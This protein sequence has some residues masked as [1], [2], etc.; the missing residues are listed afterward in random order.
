MASTSRSASLSENGRG[1]L[2]G[3]ACH[4]IVLSFQNVAH[5]KG[6]CDF[7]DILITRISSDAKILVPFTRQGF[8]P[9]FVPVDL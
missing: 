8:R 9:T 6:V 5:F 4:C 7:K 3:K 1:G 2:I